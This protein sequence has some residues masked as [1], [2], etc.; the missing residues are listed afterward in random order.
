MNN[1]HDD[2]QH[3][4]SEVKHVAWLLKEA[5]MKTLPQVAE[6]GRKSYRDDTLSCLC[7]Q[8]RNARRAWREAG[9]P[10]E[11]PCTKGKLRK[12][13]GFCAA[14]EERRRIQRREIFATRDRGS[15]TTPQAKKTRCSKLVVNVKIVS[16]PER[17]MDVRAKHFGRLTNSRVNNMDGL[18][19]LQD[20]MSHSL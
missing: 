6:R 16:E 13:I 11:G 8:S 20:K 3:I 1:S 2:A 12:R 19:T 17:L 10:A 7:V 4:Q 15:F 18:Q 5:A 9:C 14:R